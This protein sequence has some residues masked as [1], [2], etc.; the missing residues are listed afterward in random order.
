MKDWE[1]ARETYQ[2][3]NLNVEVGG[4]IGYRGENSSKVSFSLPANRT[5]VLPPSFYHLLLS[6]RSSPP[7]SEARRW[8]PR[9]AFRRHDDRLRRQGSYGGQHHQWV[10]FVF[11]FVTERRKGRHFLSPNWIY[12]VVI[13]LSNWF[14]IIVFCCRKSQNPQSHVILGFFSGSGNELHIKNV[15]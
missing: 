9:A 7:R 2:F 4:I 5:F 12:K 10:H 3:I 6:R 14:L 8:R 13:L 1:W 15:L 11:S